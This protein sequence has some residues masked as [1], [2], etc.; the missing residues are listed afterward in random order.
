MGRR[1]KATSKGPR[2]EKPAP[3]ETSAA[4]PFTPSDPK[5]PATVPPTE[6]FGRRRDIE[7]ADESPEQHDRRHHD[8]E[9]IE[10]GRPV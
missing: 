7:S 9:G 3:D 5:A 8:A 2:P 6:D 1:S 10:V 4:S